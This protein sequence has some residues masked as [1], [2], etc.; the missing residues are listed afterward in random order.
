[1][2]FATE[3][4]SVDFNLPLSVPTSKAVLVSLHLK[5][6]RRYANIKTMF[7]DA[8]RHLLELKREEEFLNSTIPDE[9]R[10]VLSKALS[11]GLR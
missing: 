3:T 1:M 9:T 4:F 11:R 2:L 5:K 6:K 7:F 8:N 10:F